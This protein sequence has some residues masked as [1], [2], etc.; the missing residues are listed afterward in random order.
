MN[1]LGFRFVLRSGNLCSFWLPPVKLLPLGGGG[2][3]V[4]LTFTKNIT[5]PNNDKIVACTNPN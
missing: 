3:G 4:L 5:T 2:G 1:L